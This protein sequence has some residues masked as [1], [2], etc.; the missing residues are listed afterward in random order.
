VSQRFFDAIFDP[1]TG[2]IS[3]PVNGDFLRAVEVAHSEGLRGAGRTVAILDSGFDMSIESLRAAALETSVT[4]VETVEGHGRHG[5]V[6]ALLVRWIA[7]D[8]RLLLLDVGMTGNPKRSELAAALQTAFAEKVD[9]VNASLE[10]TAR[11]A[12]RAASGMDPEQAGDSRPF[13]DQVPDMTRSMLRAA[14][15]GLGTE[16]LP[17]CAICAALIDKPDGSVVVSAAGND[18]DADPVCPSCNAKVIGT[19]FE[20][21]RHVLVDGGDVTVR[22][23]PTSFSQNYFVELSIPQPDGFDGTSF[24]APLISGMLAI[25]SDER[26]GSEEMVWFPTALAP[27]AAALN[28]FAEMPADRGEEDRARLASAALAGYQIVADCCPPEHQHWLPGAARACGWCAWCMTDWY[29]DYSALLIGT[30]QADIARN[31]AGLGSTVNPRSP[32]I[33]GNMAVAC[34]RLAAAEAEG[35]V[36][37]EQLLGEAAR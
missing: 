35:S 19:G 3:L 17:P 1:S 37:H 18:A 11:A 5:T 8:A 21:Q 26:T 28:L 27:A 36:E 13:V 33:A 29:R 23:F 30:G 4:S 16:C 24:A 15:A 25:S 2:R 7:P 31:V 14:G 9:V 20:R 32:E 22:G 6:V 34:T 12:E 10:F